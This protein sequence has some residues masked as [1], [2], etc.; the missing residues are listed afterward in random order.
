MLY[1]ILYMLLFFI[2]M[3]SDHTSLDTRKQHA[4]ALLPLSRLLPPQE[5]E[6]VSS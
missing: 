3:E 1:L 6:L 2:V 4:I 5:N